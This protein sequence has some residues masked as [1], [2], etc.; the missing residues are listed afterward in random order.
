MKSKILLLIVPF[1]ILCLLILYRFLLL[2]NL[3][4]H[5]LSGEDVLIGMMLMLGVILLLTGVRLHRLHVGVRSVS[6]AF[7]S[8]LNADRAEEIVISE[9]TADRGLMNTVLGIPQYIANAD[10]RNEILDKLLVVAVK[11]TEST[12]A[13]LMLYNRKT[14]EL[15]V[16]RT[17]GWSSR[18]L[19]VAKSTRSKPGEGIAGR[20][21]LD[22]E[23]IIV[24]GAGNGEE[25][26]TDEKYKTRSYVSFPVRSGGDTIGVLNLTEK[27]KPPFTK[28]E[29]NLIT[30]AVRE[31][32]LML[33]GVS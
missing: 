20:A 33:I 32:G 12:R 13:S 16:Y 21:F 27:E 7:E 22:D 5:Y 9:E 14:D 15:S 31:A 24:N 23:P 28:S 2:F 25:N 17:I 10:S 18:E 3:L 11:V 6:E 30:F 4:P 1:T 8:T 26:G 29:L 19:Q